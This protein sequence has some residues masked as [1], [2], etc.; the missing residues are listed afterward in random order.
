MNAVTVTP[1]D[2]AFVKSTWAKM[3]PITDQAAALF[4]ARL[5]E[6]DPTLKL[7]F[8]QN[9]EEQGRKLMGMIGVAV[10]NLD[11]ID[12]IMPALQE[13]GRRHQNYGVKPRDYDTVVAALLWA[14]AQCLGDEFTSEVEMSW[15]SVYT[16]LANTMKAA[17]VSEYKSDDLARGAAYSG[18]L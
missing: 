16:L 2:I 6:L 13:L 12:D 3:V 10:N 11:R 17:T 14:L 15:T 8:V 4:Y 5:F 7:L 1:R 9:M 18:P